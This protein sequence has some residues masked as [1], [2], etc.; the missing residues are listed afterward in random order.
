MDNLIQSWEKTLE[1]LKPEL[2]TI[3]Y[4]TWVA[5]LKP[6]SIDEEKGKLYLQVYNDFA[7]EERF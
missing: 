7:S 3:S 1:L 4:D 2:T 5:P 6:I